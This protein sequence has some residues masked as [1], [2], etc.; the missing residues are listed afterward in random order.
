MAEQHYFASSKAADQAHYD[1]IIQDI[2]MLVRTP[3]NTTNAAAI[4]ERATELLREALNWPD[5]AQADLLRKA[6]L[7]V[8]MGCDMCPVLGEVLPA[9]VCAALGEEV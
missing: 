8:I 3:I 5:K 4:K 6:C 7:T 9:R 1:G 2:R